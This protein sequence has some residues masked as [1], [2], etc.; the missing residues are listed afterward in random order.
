M[1]TK[2][3]AAILV[4]AL[5]A[6]TVHAQDAKPATPAAPAATATPSKPTDV[7]ADEMQILDKEKLTTFK[8]NVVAVRD[9]TTIKSPALTV[10]SVTQKQPDGTEKDVVDVIK[11]TG[12]VKIV[13]DKDVITSDWATI[14][15]QKN[16]LEAG[17]HVVLVQGTTTLKGEKLNINLD[18]NETHMSGGRVNLKALP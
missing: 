8:G 18:T 11:A 12:G 7:T 13:T 1:K 9:K 17:G 14:Y 3:A 4:T 2:L 5:T 10:Q 15:D 16:L 6:T